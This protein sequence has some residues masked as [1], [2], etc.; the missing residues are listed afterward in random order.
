MSRSTK[1]LLWRIAWIIIAVAALF[2][3]IRKIALSTAASEALFNAMPALLGVVVILAVAI[4]AMLW[5]L[6]PVFVYLA[7]QA[8]KAKLDRGNEL[9]ESIRAK[10]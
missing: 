4:W 8:I 7:L 3:I 9:L 2:F 10:I 1:R 5:I 6:F